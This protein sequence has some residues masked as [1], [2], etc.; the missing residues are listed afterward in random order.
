[1]L[2]GVSGQLSSLTD[3]SVLG[4]AFLAFALVTGLFHWAEMRVDRSVSATGAVASL[5]GFA[6][7]A[8][9]VLGD[10]TIAAAAAG[11]AATATA[12]ATTTSIVSR[13]STLN[14]A[15]TAVS[16]LNVSGKTTLLGA[17]TAVSTL[18]VS[19]NTTLLNALTSM[20]T[21]NI[22]DNITATSNLN[23]SGNTTIEGYIYGQSL[24]NITAGGTL[25]I[26]SSN[27]VFNTTGCL[28]YFNNVSQGPHAIWD[29]KC[30]TTI[31]AGP[32]APKAD[33]DMFFVQ[34][35]NLAL[36][37]VGKDGALKWMNTFTILLKKKMA[38]TL[39]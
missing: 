32:F 21:V 39:W 31:I 18:N 35:A 33:H 34:D 17:V 10:P 14:G 7:G 26:G 36:S 2:G 16:T 22:K 30:D 20:S 19:G 8:Y 28:S 38:A 1:M 29:Y 12:L 27:G 24:D 13:T 4:L 3:P 23:I 5:L 25:N 9:A 15:V 37:A 11:N 6:L